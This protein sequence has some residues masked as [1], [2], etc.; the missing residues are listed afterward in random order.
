VG[1]VA[2]ALVFPVAACAAWYRFRHS[3]P[4]ARQKVKAEP[5]VRAVLHLEPFVVNLADSEG[6][7]FLRIGIDLGLEQEL[8][9]HKR[10]GQ[11]EMPMARTRD[12]ILMILT[13]CKADGLM[14]PAGKANLKDELTRALRERVPELGVREVYFTEFLIQR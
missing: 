3:A 8:E 9:E 14:A 4:T 2:A 11:S 6:D 10:A 13:T 12:T 5:T 7:R 1:V